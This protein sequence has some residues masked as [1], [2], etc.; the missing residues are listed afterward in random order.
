MRGGGHSSEE[1][2]QGYQFVTIPSEACR[3]ATL[4]I[5]GRAR[6]DARM[7]SGAAPVLRLQIAV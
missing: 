7:V 1:G 6:R 4:P 2:A 3:K 5:R